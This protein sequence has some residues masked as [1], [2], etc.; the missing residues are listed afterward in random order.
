M[1]FWTI[2]YKIC[3]IDLAGFM[4]RPST[5]YPKLYPHVRT[6]MKAPLPLLVSGLGIAQIV[7]WGSLYY[8]IA[9]LGDS[10]QRDL[11]VSS[12]VLFAAFTLSLL[13][14]GLAAPTV[15]RLMEAHGARAVLCAGSLM[16]MAALLL[17]ACASGPVGLFLGASVAGVAM[18][19]SL[20][21]AAFMALNQLAG[22]AYR[23]CVTGLTLFGGFAST[24][25][26]PLSQILLGALGWQQTLVIYAALQ[27]VLCLP[28]HALLLPARIRPRA[29]APGAVPPAI[30]LPDTLWLAIAFAL[31]SFVLSVLSVHLI[32]LFRLAGLE[33]GSAVFIATLVGPMQVLGRLLEM[34]A[35]GKLRAVHVGTVA[36]VSMVLA[37]LGLFLLNGASILA[38]MVAGLY[39]ISNGLMTIVRG[40]VPAELYGRQNYSVLLGRL[41]RPAFLARALAPFAFPLGL[42]GLGSGGVVLALGCI[43]LLACWS[44]RAAL[45][46]A[47]KAASDASA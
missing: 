29:A 35:G 22:D 41:A 34:G 7:S 44:Y 37:L 25:S 3:G 45:R 9:V 17:L 2:L 32:K 43:S 8:P 23:R 14:S 15:G 47:G 40:V 38:F 42:A 21:D 33:A 13:I 10:M 19:A 5:A 26:W 31:A 36:F 30:V 12:T 27:L 11:G 28:L 1:S 20:Y 16:G 4:P 39:G 46:Q 24:V 6:R 18:A